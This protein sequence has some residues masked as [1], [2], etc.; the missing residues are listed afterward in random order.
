M[1]RSTRILRSSYYDSVVLMR[2]ASQ[3]KKRED[4]SEVAM[5]MGTEGNH[6]LL[7][8]VGLN[9]DESREAGPQDLII[10][11]EAKTGELSEVIIEEAAVM[12]TERTTRTENDLD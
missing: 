2:V 10:I 7:R 8:Q 3:L 11:V 12:L 9:T 6:D 1:I 4:V 5:F